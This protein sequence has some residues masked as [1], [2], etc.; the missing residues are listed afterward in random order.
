MKKQ[1]VTA[2]MT[3]MLI[4]QIMIS[5]FS[6]SG[7]AIATT[8]QTITNNSNEN[9]NEDEAAEESK[10]DSTQAAEQSAT[11][12]SKTDS[13]QA[14][15]KATEESETDSTKNEQQAIDEKEV[16][17][18]VE[19]AQEIEGQAKEEQAP[20]A[21]SEKKLT[22]KAVS[23]E[24]RPVPTSIIKSVEMLLDG[25][26]LD[27]K[28][29]E[30][31]KLG[32][33]FTLNYSLAIP[34][35]TFKAGEQ[36]KIDLPANFN[37]DGIDGG[38]I[39]E[40]GTYQV[41]DGQI[42]I[43]FSQAVE[44]ENGTLTIDG[45]DYLEA[46]ISLSS[47]LQAN[48]TNELQQTLTVQTI[49]GKEIYTVQFTPQNVD[50]FL[51]KTG[52]IGKLKADGQLNEASKNPDT[53]QWTVTFNKDKEVLRNIIFKDTFNTTKLKLQ[54]D[55]FKVIELNIGLD[56]TV[57]E[58][59]DVTT[60]FKKQT[61]NS[62]AIKEG[63]DKAYKIT[64]TTTII[65]EVATSYSN[66]AIITGENFN[67]TAEKT[68]NVSR[69]PF[70][71]KQ[72]TA[73]KTGANWFVNYNYNVEE[74]NDAVISDELSESQTFDETSL[75]IYPVSFDE[76]GTA[77]V[78]KSAISATEYDV[79][80]GTNN[81]MKVSFKNKVNTAYQLQYSTKLVDNVVDQNRVTTNVVSGNKE[82]VSATVVNRANTISKS[83]SDANFQERTVNWKIHV[84]IENYKMNEAIVKDTF[85]N[86]NL[87]YI[88][89][90][91]KVNGVAFN[92]QV[93]NTGLLFNLGKL[94]KEAVITYQTTLDTSK[95]MNFINKAQVDWEGKYSSTAESVL[96][97]PNVVKNNGEKMGSYE[98]NNEKQNYLFHWTVGFNYDLQGVK[99]G[100]EILDEFASKNMKLL[101]ETLKIN[102][103]TM[104][105]GSPVATGKVLAEDYYRITSNDNGFTLTILKDLPENVAYQMKYDTTDSD[106]VFES[107]YSNVAKSLLYGPNIN[108]A[109]FTKNIDIPN[110]GKGIEKTGAQIGKTRT[111]DFKVNVN[112]SKSILP[113]AVVS[114]ALSSTIASEKDMK[115]QFDSFYLNKAGTTTQIP[116]LLTTNAQQVPD[117]NYYLYMSEEQNTF[118]IIFPTTITDAYELAY[119]VYFEGDKNTPFKN[120]AQ[121]SFDG[122]ITSLS[123]TSVS[124]V[125]YTNNS[126]TAGWGTVIYK[127]L[128][129]KKVDASNGK[130]LQGAKFELYK[131]DDLDKA[132]RTATTDENGVAKFSNIR[133]KEQGTSPY[134]LK[135]VEAPAHYEISAEYKKGKEV[136][137]STTNSV[138]TTAFEVANE[139]E[140]CELTI[141]FKNSND[142][143]EIAANGT[144]DVYT[145]KNGEKV[146]YK[147]TQV[148]FKDGEASIK[149]A[150]GEY[151]LKQN[152]Q[153]DGYTST[154]QFTPITVAYDEDGLCLTKIAIVE[155][156]PVCDTVILNIDKD[157]KEKIVNEAEFTLFQDGKEIKTVTSKDG[158]IALGQLLSGKYELKQKTAPKDYDLNK[159][160]IN[161]TV[162]ATNC[163]TDLLEFENEVPKC[164]VTII[165]KDE[166]GQIITEGSTYKVIKNGKVIADDVKAENGTI[167]VPGLPAGDYEL[168]Q[169]KVE[170]NYELNEQPVKFTVNPENCQAII[171]VNDF[172]KCEVTI[173]NKDG[174]T[175]EVIVSGSEYKLYKKAENGEK[176]EVIVEGGIKA[177]TDGKIVLP[178]L[179]RGDYVL[180]QITSPEHYE[181]ASEL[182]FTV[183]AKD[184]STVTT[185][186]VENIMTYCP[187]TIILV[188]EELAEGIEGAQFI[189][190]DVNGQKVGESFT[191]GKDGKV[192]TEPLRPGTYTLELVKAIAGYDIA[193]ST[194]FV[195]DANKCGDTLEVNVSNTANKCDVTFFNKDSFGQVIT[196]GSTYKVEKINEDGT[197][198]IVKENIV[199]TNGKITIEQL[200][201]GKYVLTQTEAP[202]GYFMQEKPQEFEVLK[203]EC[204]TEQTIVNTI[205]DFTIVYLGAK[206]SDATFTLYDVTNDKTV[207]AENIKV[208]DGKLQMP[209]MKPGNYELVQTFIPKGYEGSEPIQFTVESGVCYAEPVTVE[210]AV[211]IPPADPEQ[212]ANPEQPDESTTTITVNDDKEILTP[213]VKKKPNVNYEIIDKNTGKKVDSSKT[214]GKGQLIVKELPK[215]TYQIVEKKQKLPQTGQSNT[216]LSS[217]LGVTVLLLG[218]LLVM[219]NKKRSKI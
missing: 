165:N 26:A 18:P 192:V 28:T 124:T 81:S 201:P 52:K 108:T 99:A 21:T 115:Y 101:A 71:N 130:S 12:E 162:D 131:T 149:L 190:K 4:M 146:P 151:F 218:L 56:G 55:T 31:V 107:R 137:F 83:Y 186:V 117:A 152:G 211:I 164:D 7:Y 145:E 75:K 160:T 155:L 70:L 92:P 105:S 27:G 163:T 205:C 193:K 84:N 157:S 100:T 219:R 167:T 37:S 148:I 49:K 208:V 111:F 210:N 144:Y 183:N 121:L 154:N 198:T 199:S 150:P 166:D 159:E 20:K 34:L 6:L 32:E 207:V 173:I 134:I 42:I 39:N 176:V 88:E 9:I 15:Q 64:Y 109:K 87:K 181:K 170:G 197:K 202:N 114:D 96:N 209:T 174:D 136:Q 54:E 187:A 171:I 161:F 119:K 61:D 5:G 78:S 66:K 86:S 142:Q 132:Y 203:D 16:A 68:F 129:V 127:D 2:L 44:N 1:I 204:L 141:N 178:T 51:I 13:T 63:S 156:V 22:T 118:K 180:K 212:P 139:H 48:E 29:I 76:N 189:I 62:W 196:E 113:N 97:I 90:T 11:E 19:K 8:D 82:S 147:N 59:Q 74:I 77:I 40:L 3:F 36:Y 25:K 184:C 41:K 33:K 153:I 158:K 194:T 169:T 172:G 69:Q 213:I 53:I 123:N 94:D 73:T 206:D 110:G 58:G 104:K 135:E 91:A 102:E 80:Y 177:G 67:K 140:A 133:L 14:E 95:H 17:V 65:D 24:K 217:L 50:S 128:F 60:D 168:L 23:E 43:T 182:E 46:G 125:T 214:N 175:D 103:V 143:K 38:T 116:L 85:V 98:W 89:G 93:T 106:Q 138:V 10:V 57:T 47:E 200:R 215:G 126:S 45:E 188:D 179:E 79:I 35:N 72:G 120:A 216:M 112:K 185:L 191:F 195:I 30:K 122:N